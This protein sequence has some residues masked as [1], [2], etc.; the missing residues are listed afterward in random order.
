SFIEISGDDAKNELR[1]A[2]STLP[3][4]SLLIVAQAPYSISELKEHTFSAVI[5]AVLITILL[6]LV[7]GAY[8]GRVVLN[9]INR[10][11]EGLIRAIESN[12]RHK[13]TVPRET[14]EFQ[15]LT[16][17][18]NVMLEKI[19]SLINS[20]KQVTDNVAHDLRSPLS[21]LRSRLEVTLLQSREE[22]EYRDA[23]SQAIEDCD[24]LLKTFN[25]LLNIAQAESGSGQKDWQRVDLAALV[26][27]LVELYQP[28]AEDKDLSLHWI[29]AGPIEI[30]GNK[31]LLSQAVSNLIENA[32]K[33]TPEGGEISLSVSVDDGHPVIQV[34]DTGPGI[35]FKDRARVLERFQRL[36]SARSSEGNGLGLSLVNAVVKS[37]HATLVFGDNNP[38]LKVEIHFQA[39]SS[40]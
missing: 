35:P 28:V 32:I 22:T 7:S 24:S 9:R 15:A 17:K 37:H 14:D 16:L 5:A 12:F 26:D 21:R 23:M 10:I 25:S 38:G 3:N 11:D 1:G 30:E 31:V 27:Q 36:D 39:R 8:M 20:M 29:L 13:L 34:S 40:K 33:Y 19:E 4:R 2:I 18:L 6:S